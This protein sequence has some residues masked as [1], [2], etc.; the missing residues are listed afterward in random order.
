MR[1]AVFGFWV[2]LYFG[3]F[4]LAEQ[5][6]A[7]FGSHEYIEYLPG[8]L[9]V[10]IS[11]PHGGTLKPGEITD[12][13]DGKVIQDSFTQELA[14]LIRDDMEKRFGAP[15]HLVICRLHRSKLDCNR[16]IGEAA[17]GDVIAAKAHAEYH[18]FLTQACGTM[19]KHFGAGLY[20][21]LHGQK[22]EERLVEIGT[23]IT[24]EKL[25]LT[26]AQ[27]D[28][29]SL[30]SRQSSIRELDARSPR[31]FAELM[32]GKTSLGGMLEARG[33]AAIPSPAYPAPKPK[34]LYFTGAYDVATHGSREGGTVSAVQVECPFEG[35]RDSKEHRAK[36]SAAFCDAM[37]DFFRVHFAMDL[38]DA[39]PRDMW[40][41]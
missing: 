12:R 5:S 14:R 40:P 29:G 8:A 20:I 19:E 36:F 6:K 33:Y 13:Q 21:D 7:V 32:R 4:A 28:V 27:L 37:E 35:V 2:A 41:H 17:Q 34:Q 1:F 18:A 38:K 31:S 26:D 24:A 39:K 9:P 25:A 16:E 15:P 11:A 30:V 3:G 10:V 22:H 23:L